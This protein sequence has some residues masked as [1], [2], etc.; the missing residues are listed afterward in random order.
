[1]YFKNREEAGDK[2]ARKLKKYKTQNCVVVALSPGAV[3]VGARIAEYLHANLMILLT[4]NINLPGE[5]E[6][7]AAVASD[8][9]FT[10]NALFSLGEIE[11]LQMDFYQ[12]IE[13]ERFNKLHHLHLLLGKHGEIR[14][15]RLKRHVI[16]LVSDGLNTGFSLDIAINYLKT[17]NSPKVVAVA[18]FASPD[19]YDR[20]RLLFD[21]YYC[22]NLI[23]NYMGVNHYYDNNDIPNTEKL[24]ELSQNISL[25]WNVVS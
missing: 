4:E 6:P 10:Y 25:N 23:D 20:M 3:L 5:P 12:Y 16:I 24:L 8:N 19:A 17:V 1:M 2:L 18:P 21:D 22:L 15:D 13:Q 7:I 11:E 14:K 9:S